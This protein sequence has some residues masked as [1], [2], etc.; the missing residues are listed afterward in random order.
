MIALSSN[1]GRET[2]F[3][4][5]YYKNNYLYTSV[6]EADLLWLCFSQ[7]GQI[8]C[9]TEYS[10]SD[11]SLTSFNF[12][13]NCSTCLKPLMCETNEEVVSWLIYSYVH[14]KYVNTV[15]Q[16]LCGLM[17]VESSN[18]TWTTQTSIISTRRVQVADSEVSPIVRLTKQPYSE[19]WCWVLMV[20]RH[21]WH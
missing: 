2:H 3:S 1:S 4:R 18:K 6:K 7:L 11:L 9:I 19:W 8:M 13:T 17:V 16:V 15:T 20:N 5:D 12:S 10:L 14:S 21:F